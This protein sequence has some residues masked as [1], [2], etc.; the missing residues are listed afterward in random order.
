MVLTACGTIPGA[1]VEIAGMTLPTATALDWATE[2]AQATNPQG[3]DVDPD[4]RAQTV[5]GQLTAFIR[6]QLALDAAKQLGI[7]VTDA[8][9]NDSIAQYDSYRKQSGAQPL[10]TVMQVSNDMVREVIYDLLV[11]NAIGKKLPADGADVTDV[12]VNIDAVPADNWADAVAARVKYTADPAAMTADAQAAL[13]ANPGLPGGSESLLQQPHHAMFGIFS[14]AD[15]EIMLIP[16]GNGSYLVTRV[17]DRAESPAKLTERTISAAYQT[18]GVGGQLAVGSLL[19]APQ[20]Q[21]ASITVNS[22]FGRF[23]PR[24]VQVVAAP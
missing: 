19:L 23:D 20:A 4:L 14:A 7:T 21:D 16:N 12:T 8:D 3:T 13:A 22:R 11:M 18:A 6:H 5:R 9:I 2:V 10:A 1:A 15:G 24:I 17:T